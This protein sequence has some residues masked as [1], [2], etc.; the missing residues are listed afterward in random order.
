M[1]SD[2]TA[3]ELVRDAHEM[4]EEMDTDVART[5]ASW[6]HGGQGSAFYAF[7]S[8]GHYDR[9]DLL[10]E[11]SRTIEQS[12]RSTDDDGRLQLDMLG[13]YFLNRHQ[14]H[15]SLFGTYWCDT[16]DSPYC[17]LA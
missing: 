17:E 6:W 9:D 2:E 16:C 12:Y 11:L 10:R 3:R 7:S 15:Y 13:T 4:G 8:S 5:V 1:N 14:G